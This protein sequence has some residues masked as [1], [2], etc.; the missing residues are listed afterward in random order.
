M[1]KLTLSHINMRAVNTNFP[2]QT[3]HHYLHSKKIRPCDMKQCGRIELHFK[4]ASPFALPGVPCVAPGIHMCIYY[5]EVCFAGKNTVFFRRFKHLPWR[6]LWL[7]QILQRAF[8]SVA[9]LCYG[10]SF[11]T[12]TSSFPSCKLLLA[13]KGLRLGWNVCPTF[14]GLWCLLCW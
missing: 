13:I 5:S 14:V 4:W 6:K 1:D 12:T 2:C 8:G 7:L 9:R 10:D 3:H 11:W